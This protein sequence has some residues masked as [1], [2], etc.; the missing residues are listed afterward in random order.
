MR[1]EEEELDEAGRRRQL[2]DLKRQVMRKVDGI[3]DP[4]LLESIL[5]MI[6]D[7]EGDL[8]EGEKDPEIVA[9]SENDREHPDN[10]TKPAPINRPAQNDAD[11]WLDGLGR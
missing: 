3:T 4:F 10:R 1:D 5:E 6:E 7:A 8:M 2:Q 9:A 11:S